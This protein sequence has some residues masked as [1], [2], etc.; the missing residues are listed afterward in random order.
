MYYL[1]YLRC[2]QS[3]HVANVVNDVDGY[4]VCSVCDFAC[5]LKYSIY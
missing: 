3:I 1:T 4:F 5:T 2:T